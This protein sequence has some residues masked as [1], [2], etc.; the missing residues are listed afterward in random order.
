MNQV[1]SCFAIKQRDLVYQVRV[2]NRSRE[3]RVKVN[4]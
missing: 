3:Y 4:A 2:V 1:I